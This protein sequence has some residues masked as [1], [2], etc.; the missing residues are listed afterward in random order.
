MAERAPSR[1]L[2]LQL[3]LGFALATLLLLGGFALVMDATL[4]RSLAREDAL[5][6]EGQAGYL[7]RVLGSE[8]TPGEEH[9]ARPEKAEW[10]LSLPGQPP[11]RSAGFLAQP[12]P[13]WEAVPA[14]GRT[15]EV[16]LPGGGEASVLRRPFG[17]GE[18]RLL[19]DRRH[20]GTLITS[21]RQALWIG[22]LLAAALA[23]L[24]GRGVALRGLRPLRI[25]AE[26]TAAIQPGDPFHPLDP[27]QFPRELAHLVTTLNGALQ[28]L[29]SAIGRLEELG[30]ELAHE[31]RTP[32]QHLR[33][34]LEDLALGR[35]PLDPQ[36]LGP[37]LEACDR[38][39][40][41][42]EGILFLARSEDPN[43]SLRW[44]SV[45]VGALLASTREFFE[46]VAE[47]AR[48]HLAVAAP[49]DLRVPGDEVLLQRAL[50]NLM[51]NA[52]AVTPPGRTIRLEGALQGTEVLLCVVDEGPGVPEGVLA[53]LGARWNRGGHGRGHGLG[54]AIVA[55]IAALHGGRF[56]FEAQAPFGTCAVLR[57]PGL[58]HLKND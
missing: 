54:L 48:V 20:E 49:P 19:L 41:L 9:G 3:Q 15:H 32:L 58:R 1:S 47:E 8:G 6:L 34:H 30:G 37:S 22:T 46:G 26:E 5:V 21:F 13:R 55:S 28:R 33:S 56:S 10:E 45:D 7:A 42:I 2:V 24:L 57:L 52:L 43:A 29:Q 25:L 17:Q 23:A 31:L 39:Q 27:S 4:H 35:T 51:S 11:R 12:A 40:S 16:E 44:T 50:H 36:A 53:N 18:L 38:L 14:D